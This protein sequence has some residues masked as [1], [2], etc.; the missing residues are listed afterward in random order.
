MF[1]IWGF[2]GSKYLDSDLPGTI[3]CSLESGYQCFTSTLKKK[4]TNYSEMMV[5][6]Y[7]TTWFHNP[8]DHS[9]KSIC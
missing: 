6:T 1:E 8:Q 3:L 4:A 2:H 9:L 7:Q 5:T